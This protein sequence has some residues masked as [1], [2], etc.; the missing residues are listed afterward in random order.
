MNIFVRAT[1]GL[2]GALLLAGA[3]A[4]YTHPTSAQVGPGGL[5]M[6]HVEGRKSL[7]QKLDA[8]ELPKPLPPSTPG[9]PKAGAAYKNVQVL[10]DLT[11]A[12][13]TRF[14]LT[15]T[16]WVSPDQGCAYCHAPQKDKNGKLVLDDD[17]APQADLGRMWSDELYTKQV[18]R[19]MLQMTLRINGEWQTHVKN[20]GVTCWTCHRG[21]PVPKQIWFD[22]PPVAEHGVVGGT[23]AQ[24]H[25]ASSVG[26]TSL[27]TTAFR[28]FF[29][30]NEQIRIISTDSLGA[31]QNRSSIK[32]AEWTYGLMMHMSSALGV[33]C[34]HC[35]N[36]RS[37]A[38]WSSSPPQRA[39]AWYGIRMVRE[40]NLGYLEGLQ[41]TFP[42]N[43]LGPMGDA[44]KVNCATCHNGAY[45]PLLGVSMLPD[46]P[47]LAGTPSAVQ[48]H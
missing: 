19:R 3:V 36:T 7:A 48:P 44:P 1:F 11:T 46:Y 34:T 16:Q 35:H 26:L 33:N 37:M 5:A 9:G 4:T 8:N 13:F 6:E 20:T 27:P 47:Y 18:A 41:D 28:P 30:S 14:M 39:Q 32:Q 25:P 43:R 12:E 29:A 31:D 23:Q 42:A 38:E 40:L 10:G 45:K 2:A 15:I 24:N 22:E 17:G 21:N